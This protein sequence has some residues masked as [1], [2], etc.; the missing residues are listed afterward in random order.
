MNTPILRSLL[1]AS[2]LQAIALPSVVAQTHSADTDTDNQVNF[3]EL[4]RVV[5]LYNSTAFHCD[6]DSEDGYAPDAGDQSCD[7]HDADYGPADWQI[8]LSELLRLI[9][10]YNS[11]AYGCSLATEDGFAPGSGTVEECAEDIYAGV[12]TG[13]IADNGGTLTFE[14]EAPDGGSKAAGIGVTVQ[15]EGIV[16]T[17][18]DGT[19][20]FR[21]D[22][23]APG[24][25]QLQAGP[26]PPIQIP[27]TVI[28]N[29][30][31][32][33]GAYPVSREAALAAVLTEAGLNPEDPARPWQI[34]APNHP[35][36]A[37]SLIT[38]GLGDENG[39]NNPALYLRLESPKWFVFENKNSTLSW[40]H[41]VVYWLVDPISGELES[42]P[43]ESWPII[44]GEDYYSDEVIDIE[45]QDTPYL[46]IEPAIPEGEGE[47]PLPPK[48]VLTQK[49]TPTPCCEDPKTYALL[50]RGHDDSITGSDIDDVENALGEG[51]LPGQLILSHYDSCSDKPK[52]K[53]LAKFREVCQ[54]TRPCDTL[55]VY[56]TAHGTRGGIKLEHN[57]FACPQKIFGSDADF[58]TL[59]PAEI[60]WEECAA[61]NL[62][63]VVD[64]CHSGTYVSPAQRTRFDKL[65]GKRV[66]V[67]TATNLNKEAGSFGR[68]HLLRETGSV[69]TNRLEDTIDSLV[70]GVEGWD[71]FGVDPEG[72]TGLERVFDEAARRVANSFDLW[73]QFKNQSPEFYKRVPGPGEVCGGCPSTSRCTVTGEF[74]AELSCGFPETFSDT[75]NVTF[76][77]G[78]V[79]F[80]QQGTLDTTTGSIDESGNFFVERPGGGASYD[81]TFD[82]VTC[83]G[84][85]THH[86]EASPE[87]TAIY[88]VNFSPV[89]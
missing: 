53:F 89:K 37:G 32:R 52:E 85:A 30:E 47:L 87:C 44:N 6:E 34:Q 12:I 14:S 29:A 16:S 82:D 15:L 33:V 68:E 42:Y 7:L 58:N 45:L 65:T 48:A 81:G 73:N 9:Q 3:S 2:L 70:D 86:Y 50:V 51:L 74:F 1:L 60:P 55:F 31:I 79:T 4:L 24:F 64:A 5:Q 8:G 20:F 39:N 59:G 88:G 27:L 61:C 76:D 72:K 57:A 77:A 26:Q 75:F 11:E 25:Y 80:V 56:M 84:F 38:P 17:T 13:F 78:T 49:S 43:R 41:P 83:T 35:L 67:M 46:P 19:G 40:S 36:P 62:V 22:G 54:Q 23:V 18:T 63:L 66:A 10:I 71:P 28:N 21:L 69:F